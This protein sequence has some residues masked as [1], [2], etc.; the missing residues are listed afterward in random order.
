MMP[1]KNNN[2]DVDIETAELRLKGQLLQHIRKRDKGETLRL[3]SV[4]GKLSQ[5]PEAVEQTLPNISTERSVITE[6]GSGYEV[7]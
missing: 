6:A 2:R 3:P 5:S 1:I 4:G 7:L